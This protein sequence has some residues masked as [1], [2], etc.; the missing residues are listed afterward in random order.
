M[1][2]AHTCSAEAQTAKIDQA[3]FSEP[4]PGD[5]VGRPTDVLAFRTLDI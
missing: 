4:V 2:A 5:V 3:Q 1:P